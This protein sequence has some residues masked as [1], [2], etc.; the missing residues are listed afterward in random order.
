M[1]GVGNVLSKFLKK[2]QYILLFLRVTKLHNEGTVIVDV[3]A[4]ELTTQII[5]NYFS[6]TNTSL[7]EYCVCVCSVGRSHFSN[8]YQRRYCWMVDIMKNHTSSEFQ[9]VF[10]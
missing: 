9:Q 7:L 2:L 10:P 3:V 6:C 1:Q 8:I 4:I 5:P